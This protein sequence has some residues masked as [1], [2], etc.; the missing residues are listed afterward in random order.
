MHRK[1]FNNVLK[2]ISSLFGLLSNMDRVKILVLLLC[3]KELDVHDLQERV[4]VS[5]S[6][7][8]QHLKLLRLNGLIEERREGKHMFYHI[9]NKNIARVVASAIQFQLINITDPESIAL[10][11]ELNKLWFV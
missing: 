2:P 3:N 8:S 1:Q 9:K 4:G 5:Q 11:G 6:R 7:A 10:L